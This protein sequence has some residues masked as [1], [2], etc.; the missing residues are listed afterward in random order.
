MAT[1]KVTNPSNASV[2][3][4]SSHQAVADAAGTKHLADSQLL[5]A[6][7]GTPTLA[8]SNTSTSTTFFSNTDDAKL[9]FS[10]TSA[11]D[12]EKSA[13]ASRGISVSQM[14]AES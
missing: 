2:P 13:I 9:S 10:D 8:P 5:E 3:V 12:G 7:A 6:A 14:P 11:D 4:L 1:D